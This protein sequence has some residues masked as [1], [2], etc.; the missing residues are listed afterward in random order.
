MEEYQIEN[1]KFGRLKIIFLMVVLLAVL[2]AVSVSFYLT[3]A[4]RPAS[5]G[6]QTV[7]FLVESGSSTKQVAKT[8][9]EQ[10][11]ISSSNVFLAYAY[12]HDASNKIQAGEYELSASMSI[13]EI[14]DVLTRGKVIPSDRSITILEGW[15]N[16]QIA[17]D[18]EERGIL[19]S[20]SDF[21]NVLM[22]N[23]YEFRFNDIAKPFKYEGFL[24]PDTYKINRNGTAQDLIQKMLANLDGKITDAMLED[25]QS[26]GKN[27]T[28]VIILA[29]IIEKE[30][31]RNKASLTDADLELMQE[32]R[33]LVASVFYNRLAIGMGL[34][35]DATVNYITG[36]GMRSVTL[37]DTKIDSPYNTYRYKGLPPGPISNPSLDSILAAIYP[38]DSGY[39]YFLNSPEGQAYFGKTLQEHAQ[40]REKYLR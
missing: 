2:A 14:I 5:E 18:L 27:L 13:A 40:N 1:T 4:Y 35:S 24:Y 23:E 21:N 3:K 32:E 11:L 26:S 10:N 16:A 37:A 19:E 25:I 34:E 7:V 20:A 17:K 31:G 36:K 12:I 29:S 8:L 15:T 33:R 30:V 28:D 22:N 6:S 38:T 9:E 39:L